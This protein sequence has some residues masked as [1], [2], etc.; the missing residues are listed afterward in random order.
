MYDIEDN[1][2]FHQENTEQ[3]LKQI[4]NDSNGTAEKMQIE[5]WE[6]ETWWRVPRTR[7]HLGS[8]SSRQDPS[9]S[10]PSSPAAAAAATPGDGALGLEARGA[11][12]RFYSIGHRRGP[13]KWPD[14]TTTL[15]LPG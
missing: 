10:L 8:S 15:P 13:V 7:C 6:M 3:W 2:L 5:G 12:D 1:L 4:Q 9:A 14:A 11:V